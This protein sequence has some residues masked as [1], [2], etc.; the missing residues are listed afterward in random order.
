MNIAV[1]GGDV[2]CLELIKSIEQRHFKEEIPRVTAVADITGRGLCNE[3]AGRLG[4]FV[5]SDYHDLLQRDDIDLIIDLTDEIEVRQDILANKKRTIRYV[6]SETYRLLLDVFADIKRLQ[7]IK[8]LPKQANVICDV[9]L[10]DLIKEDVM[11]IG[12]DYRILNVNEQL[13]E[14]L[15]LERDEIIGKYCYEITHRRNEPCSGDNH[16]CPLNT[17][18][19]TWEPFQTTHIH[20]DKNGDNSYHSISTYPLIENGK[21]TGAIELSRNITPDINH[22]KKLVQQEKLVSIGRLSAGVAHEINNPLTTILTTAMLLQE[23]KDPGEEEFEELQTVVNET[24]RCRKIVTSLLDFA[25]QTKPFKKEYDIN[26][27]ALESVLLTKKQAA[28]SDIALDKQLDGDI[29]D[30][31]IDKGQIQQVLINMLLN[32][33]EA[34]EAGGN[35]LLTTS[36][37]KSAGRIDIAVSDTGR[38]IPENELN[39]V[40]EPFFTTKENGTGLGLAISHGIIEQHNGKID[41]ESAPGKGATFTI[42]LP[43]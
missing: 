6:N 31:L 40:F 39:S 42:R 20:M 3:S 34:T 11:I 1:V 32:A 38:G 24:L 35:V 26:E 4:A 13:Q 17:T 41:V 30:I 43:V 23:E 14:K 12:A 33:I 21:V 2:L 5:T 22:Q 15:G 37:D 9:V 19:Q 10:N 25:R 16:P 29:P 18:L 7:E 8:R 27:I 36:M 28:F